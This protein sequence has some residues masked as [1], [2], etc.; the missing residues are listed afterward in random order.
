MINLFTLLKKI[1]NV[2]NVEAIDD[3]M[4]EAYY[5]AT[6]EEQTTEEQTV[7]NA[8]EDKP[9]EEQTDDKPAEE[10]TPPEEVIEEVPATPEVAEV[11]VIEEEDTADE[12]TAE[13]TAKED[14][15]EDK[16][17]LTKDVIN[18]A[19]STNYSC[20]ENLMALKGDAFFNALHKQMSNLKGLN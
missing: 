17:V 6:D 1:F 3:A 20:K 4:I 14:D 7:E 10:V 9:T 16:E 2:D 18:N 13:D 11:E 8:D 15:E 12:Q 5:N 19:T